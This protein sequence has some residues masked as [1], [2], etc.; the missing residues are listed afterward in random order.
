MG[1]SADMGSGL[2]NGEEN[3][4]GGAVVTL[5]LLVGPGADTDDDARDCGKPVTPVWQEHK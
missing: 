2:A 5:F 3:A 1:K 4:S